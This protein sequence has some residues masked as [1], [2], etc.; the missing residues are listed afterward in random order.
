MSRCHPARPVLVLLLLGAALSPGAGGLHA[1]DAKPKAPP[2]A[3]EEYHQFDFWIGEWE[4][5]TDR[6]RE[7]G[8]PPVHS[9]VSR[10]ADGC[11]LLEEYNAPWGYQGRSLTYFDRAAGV[12]RQTWVDSTATPSR[13]S[14]GLIGTSMVFQREAED[15][16]LHEM[17]W[18]PR[19][20]GTIQQT[21]RVTHDGGKTWTIR[22]DGTY[23]P[24]R[25]GGS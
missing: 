8:G 20:D 4:V 22:F 16:L 7:A 5:W 2:C 25:T 18:K 12:W 11:A 9:R 24:I 3:S 23:R 6:I 14:G 1:A 15:G 10:I 13:Q 19:S 21:W 17:R